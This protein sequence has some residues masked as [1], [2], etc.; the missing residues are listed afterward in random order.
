MIS[1][2]FHIGDKKRSKIDKFW[3]QINTEKISPESFNDPY[4]IGLIND[5]RRSEEWGVDPN[6]SEPVLLSK[7]EFNQIQEDNKF[8]LE[9]GKEIIEKTCHLIKGSPGVLVLADK[10]GT[11]LH[12]AGDPIVRFKAEADSKITEGAKWHESIVG[13]N[14]IGTP[15][16]TKMP[17]HIFASEHFCEAWHYWTCTGAPILN[18]YNNEVLGVIDYTSVEKDYKADAM[19]LVF[20]IAAYITS[21]FKALYLQE[22]CELIENFSAYIQRYPSDNIIVLDK[23]GRVVKSNIDIDD[24]RKIYLQNNKLL[25]NPPNEVHKIYS[26]GSTTEIGTLLVVTSD[27]SPIKREQIRVPF[28]SF[29]GFITASDQVLQIKERMEKIIP[30]NLNILIIGETGVGKELIARY[31][32]DQSKRQNGP[33]VAVNC[34]AIGKDLFESRLFGYERGSFT[35]ADPKGRKGLFESANGGTLFLDELGELPFDMQAAFLRVLDTKRFSRIGA[36]KEIK[37]DCRIIA[38]TNCNLA[39]YVEKGT[40]RAD[41]FYRLNTTKFQIPPLRDRVDDI[42]ILIDSYAKRFCEEHS[43]P[44]PKFDQEAIRCLVQHSW[45]GNV[46]ELK[47]V[48]GTTILIAGNSVTPEDLPLEITTP[49]IVKHDQ[50]HDKNKDPQDAL[51]GVEEHELSFRK[52]EKDLIIS[53]LQQNKKI[54]EVAKI[55]GISRANLYRKFKVLNI[56]HKNV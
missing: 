46:R 9:K 12:I 37:V 11:I 40:F 39:E 29:G 55:L 47:N 3:Y 54:K 16:I 26:L 20:T 32:H 8:L 19:G 49:K 24:E 4:K 15:V 51:G 35:G 48:I 38:A 1:Q 52:N 30:T 23:M 6:D 18:P 34:G 36:H 10:E 27:H 2:N 22:R 53:A 25:T 14:G 56:D 17:V 31:I 21:E 28:T 33:Y 7:S 43:M 42:P 44:L 45:A 50:Q 41:L 5:W 13:Y